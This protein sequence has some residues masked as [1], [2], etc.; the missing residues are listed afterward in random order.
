MLDNYNIPSYGLAS[1]ASA[2]GIA[3]DLR[4][5]RARPAIDWRVQQT[6]STADRPDRAARA[7]D[8]VVALAAL[9]VFAPVMLLAAVAILLTSS[10]PVLFRQQRIGRNGRFFS[11]IKFRTM[12][13]DAQQMLDSLLATDPAA[14]A[15]WHHNH[16]LRNDPR[17]IG[18]GNFLR[19]TSLDELPQLFNV[20]AG[21]MA[22][23]GP[24]PIIASEIA[25]YGRH[26]SAYCSVRPGITGLWQVT[27]RSDTC[28]RRRVA[29]DQLYARR[30]S[31]LVDFRIILCTVPVVLLGSGAC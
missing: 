16:K 5:D 2:S 3:T 6:R 20:L 27:G 29:C 7:L 14:R 18:I 21:D 15:E 24:R 19:R 25:R 12:H 17:I 28:F 31:A 9:V 8:I 23:V 22:I 11:C 10:G 13:V 30:K 26:F 4:S 1:G